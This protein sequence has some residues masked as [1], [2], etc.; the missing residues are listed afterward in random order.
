MPT[1]FTITEVKNRALDMVGEFPIEGPSDNGVYARW[2]NRNYAPTVEA[3]LRQQPWNF[4]CAF[5]QL[6]EDADAPIMRWRRSYGLPNGWLRV[7]QPTYNG[8]R[9]GR[10][11]KFAVQGNRVLTNE[12]LTK[13]V[14]LV[15]NIQEPGQ[16]DPLFADFIAARLATG[17]AHR[18]TAKNSFVDRCKQLANEAYEQ[19]ELINSFE[20]S[21][22]TFED[23]D[24]IRARSGD[25]WR[26]DEWGGC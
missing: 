14:E 2:L 12:A 4:A 24:I 19:A 16:W 8:L 3:A 18:F 1:S 21:M 20:G 10:P 25:D 17:M 22:P 13:G 23:H 15:M 9:E 6:V 7:L 11:I 26:N 5:Y